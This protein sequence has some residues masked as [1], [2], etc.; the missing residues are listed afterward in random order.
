M[1]AVC[2]LEF[3]NCQ[4]CS[5]LGV[6]EQSTARNEDSACN[7]NPHTKEISIYLR[8]RQYGEVMKSTSPNSAIYISSR[9]GQLL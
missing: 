8:G 4:S 6:I 5:L 1:P 2:H 3:D 7:C 9:I